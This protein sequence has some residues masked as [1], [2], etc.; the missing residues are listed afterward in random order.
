M[1]RI[2]AFL[3]RGRAEGCSDIHIA[4][5][6]PPI[7]R[8]HGRLVAVA[9]RDL[10]AKEVEKLLTEII[11]DEQHRTFESGDDLDFTYSAEGIGRY[12]VNLFKKLGGLGATFRV[13]GN[14]VPSLEELLLPEVIENLAANH[15]GLVLVTGAAGTGKS[16]TLAAMVDFLNK[17]RKINIITL[18]DPIEYLHGP[19]RSQIVQREVGEHVNS[20]ADGLRA[21]LR[22]DPDVILVGEMRD[23]ETI[24]LALEAAETGHLVLG[25]LHTA[26][27]VKTLDRVIDAMPAQQKSQTAMILAHHLRG[28]VSQRLLRTP[29]GNGRR[30]VVEILVNTPAIASLVQHRKHFLIADQLQT[31]KEHGMQLMDQALK[32]AVEEGHVDPNEAYLLAEDKKPLRRYVTDTDILPQVSMV[33][34]R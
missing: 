17:T 23:R 13:I 4:P 21:A 26:S 11:T 22:E 20:F 14:R 25:T 7:F 27:A 29:D 28:V 30:A 31:G 15:Q 32:R 1:A 9:Y 18:E 19:G 16:T 2:D 24:S 33:G 5:G 10:D 34:G 12:R 6:R 3:K 8:L